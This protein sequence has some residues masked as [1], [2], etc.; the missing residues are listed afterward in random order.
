MEDR[1][2]NARWQ[3]V[4]KEWKTGDKYDKNNEKVIN[5]SENMTAN[6]RKDA[7]HS[8]SLYEKVGS[9]SLWQSFHVVSKDLGKSFFFS[10][11]RLALHP[12]PRQG[13]GWEVC[14]HRSIS[15]SCS[16]ETEYVGPQKRK[17]DPAP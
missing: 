15:A 16:T 4:T 9:E 6:V 17:A 11:H 14:L 3:K 12:G 2:T 7:L 8:I 5:N 13:D 1:V 10:A